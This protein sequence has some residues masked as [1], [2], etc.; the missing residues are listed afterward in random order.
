MRKCLSIRLK[1]SRVLSGFRPEMDPEVR[2]IRRWKR[3]F[4][5]GLFGITLTTALLI[6]RYKRK[7]WFELIQKTKRLQVMSFYLIIEKFLPYFFRY[8]IKGSKIW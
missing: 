4:A 2:R 1:N 8:L 3:I 7:Q 5:F 6:K